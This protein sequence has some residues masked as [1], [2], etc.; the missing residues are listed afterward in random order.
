[1]GELASITH[2]GH[3]LRFS[4]RCR[5]SPW[6]VNLCVADQSSVVSSL[7]MGGSESKVLVVLET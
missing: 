7:A 4:I 1:M 3:T 6:M 2:V 5:W